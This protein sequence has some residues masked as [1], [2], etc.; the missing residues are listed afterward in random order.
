VERAGVRTLSRWLWGL[1]LIGAALGAP[2]T[3]AATEA[4]TER[5]VARGLAW[6]KQHPAAPDDGGILDMIDEGLFC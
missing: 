6:V 5:T 4:A 2:T 1:V 3:V